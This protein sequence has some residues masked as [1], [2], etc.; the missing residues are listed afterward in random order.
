VKPSALITAFVIAGFGQSF[1]LV[2]LA[3][4]A[5]MAWEP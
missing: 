2:L 1:P 3:L 5:R 4:R